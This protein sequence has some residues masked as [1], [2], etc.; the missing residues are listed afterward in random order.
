MC[1]SVPQMPVRSTLMST[2]LM[3]DLGNVHFPE[4]E[5]RLAPAFHQRPHS[6]TS[7]LAI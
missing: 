1:T 2:S 7:G 4:P 3:P 5:A 6:F